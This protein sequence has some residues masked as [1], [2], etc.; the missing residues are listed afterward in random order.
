LSRP[1]YN[2]IAKQWHE[3]TGYHGGPFKRYVLNDYLLTTIGTI[4]NLSII[5]LGA[6]N[7]YF[8][9]LMLR[10][11]SG[12]IPSRIVIT[13]QSVALLKIAENEFRVEG[14]EYI[15]LDIRNS[16]PFGDGSFDIILATM[17]F[18]EVSTPNVR[19][20]L[21][22]CHRILRENGRMIATVAHPSFITTLFRGGKLSKLGS[23]FWTMPAKGSLRV[24]VVPRSEEAYSELF[25]DA[26]I[27]FEAESLYP[28][29][30]VLNERPGL[31]HAAGVPLAMVFNCRK[32]KH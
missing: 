19:V 14:A 31:S 32:S 5:E 12:Q 23:D 3:A 26:D 18:N 20:A 6:G 30:S 27:E 11:F 29:P 16:F 24:P 25:R 8:I 28:S 2:R 21:K 10:Q 22:E 4:G 1:Y 17:V 9:P 7:G 15:Q 13:D